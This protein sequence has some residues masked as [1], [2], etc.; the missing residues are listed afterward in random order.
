M[1]IVLDKMKNYKILLAGGELD[2]ADWISSNN[3]T[4]SKLEGKVKSIEVYTIEGEGHI[5]SP[6]YDINKVY[7]KYFIIKK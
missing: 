6:D 2:E 3:K 4:K 7:S 1:K 5:I